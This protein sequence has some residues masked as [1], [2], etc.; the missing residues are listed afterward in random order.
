MIQDRL[1]SRFYRRKTG[2][3]H[4]LAVSFT[5]KEILSESFFK[6][7]MAVFSLNYE[8]VQTCNYENSLIK[9]VC[10]TAAYTCVLLL[11]IIDKAR[12]GGGIVTHRGNLQDL[13]HLVNF[14]TLITKIDVIRGNSV[15]GSLYFTFKPRF[16][17][18]LNVEQ[19][20]CK[21]IDFYQL[22]CADCK[23]LFYKWL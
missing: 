4:S 13:L 22:R 19:K 7:T 23:K 2:E 3:M 21:W 18:N 5:N 20:F 9:T 8:L 14:D 10:F 17:P 12:K 16:R 15:P 1:C 11:A 6:V